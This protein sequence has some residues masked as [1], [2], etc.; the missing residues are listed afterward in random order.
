MV[1]CGL[2]IEMVVAGVIRGLHI[3]WHSIAYILCQLEFVLDGE[4]KN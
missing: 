4:M 2:H 3:E 1:V